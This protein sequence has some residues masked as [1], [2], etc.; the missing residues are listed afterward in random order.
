M[1]LFPIVDSHVHLWNPAQFRY[2]W[3]DK[4]PALDR[5]YLP[6]DFTASSVNSNVS[7]IIF[8]EGGL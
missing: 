6:A 2:A 7:K 4:L 8:V 3:L 1:N 5:A